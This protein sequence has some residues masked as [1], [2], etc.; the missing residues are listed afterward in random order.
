[1]RCLRPRAVV[2]VQPSIMK[3]LLLRW[4]STSSMPWQAN[5]QPT[6]TWPLGSIAARGHA[7]F[8]LQQRSPAR[9]PGEAR[10]HGKAHEVQDGRR[11][12]ARQ[13]ARRDQVVHRVAA[14]HAQAVRLLAHRHGAQLGRKRA[15]HAACAGMYA[16]P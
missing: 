9:G 4:V 1:M 6:H 8:L 3:R 10:T 11:D 12:H 13:H 2:N 7:N 15:A 16:E 5:S 14:Q